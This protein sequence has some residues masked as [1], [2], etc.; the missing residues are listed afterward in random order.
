M[1]SRLQIQGETIHL[2]DRLDQGLSTQ[3]YDHD[4]VKDKRLSLRFEKET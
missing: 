1:V 4:Q 2:Y 3:D